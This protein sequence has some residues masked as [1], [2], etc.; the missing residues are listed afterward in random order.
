VGAD[1]TRPA[2]TFYFMN[3]T[4]DTARNV[5]SSQFASARNSIVSRGG[6][7]EI[8]VGSLPL[9]KTDCLGVMTGL[10]GFSLFGTGTVLLPGSFCDHLTSY[11][12][13]YDIDSQTKTTEWITWGAG[14]S[15]GTIEEPCNY[16]GKF[17]NAM[18][19]AHY[20]QG[21]SL[22]E[23]WFRSL[24]F[25]PFQ[26][27]FV[28][29]PL[30]RP[31]AHIPAVSVP[32]APTGP[33]SGLLALTPSATTSHPT[34]SITAFELLINGV[35]VQTVPTGG[36]FSIETYGLDDGHADVRVLAYDD[37]TVK[38]YGRW[39]SSVVID[40]YG[41][42]TSLS[43]VTSS[44]NLATKFDFNVAGSG[45]NVKEIRLLHNGRVVAATQGS[46]GTLSVHGQVLGAGTCRLRAQTE[47][48]DGRRSR[49]SPVTVTVA[50]T[51]T[52]SNVAPVA[53]SYRKRLLTTEAHVVELP[54]T[55]DS[56][57]SGPGYT[58]T[59]VSGP[60]M[61]AT[62]GTYAGP[63]RIFR[64]MSG[65]SGQEDVTFTV[66]T[67]GGESNLATV[68]LI[69]SECPADFDGSGFVD[70]DDFTDFVAMFELGDPSADFDRSG[71]VDTDDYDAFVTAFEQGC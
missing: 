18:L 4:A 19:H 64:P 24:Q 10:A 23:A 7:A 28:G 32:D 44:G 47:Y 35:V 20:F 56:V 30:A 3:N 40:N 50:A 69:Y 9:G 11:A 33:V 37:T 5:R 70:L 6:L 13:A 38:S 36:Q 17:P 1:G 66:T 22:G 62:L 31:F 45:G 39:A 29:D 42:S 14:G 15:S 34:A 41:R 71:F 65:A 54:A 49:S 60:T 51:G 46:S 12:A 67:P 27:N 57:L 26:Q 68:T 21:L 8:I 59:I 55:H 48:N 52:P 53:Y 43:A 25:I 2:G 16:T 58:Y 63:Y 61:A